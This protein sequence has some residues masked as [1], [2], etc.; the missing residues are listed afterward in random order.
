MH[1]INHHMHNTRIRLNAFPGEQSILSAEFFL[2][3]VDLFQ[4]ETAVLF[5][6]VLSLFL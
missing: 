1:K 6:V 4:I 5:L 2:L 3:V